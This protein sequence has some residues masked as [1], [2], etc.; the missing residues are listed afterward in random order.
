MYSYSKARAKIVSHIINTPS[1]CYH[2]IFFKP[3]QFLNFSY[4]Y[5]IV[6]SHTVYFFFVFYRTE[7]VYVAVARMSFALSLRGLSRFVI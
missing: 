6:F 5:I 1:Y 2:E 3:F 4:T 7:N